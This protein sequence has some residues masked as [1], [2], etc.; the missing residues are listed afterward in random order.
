M[1][2]QMERRPLADTRDERENS[3]SWQTPDV[4]FG[5]RRRHWHTVSAF[6]WIAIL[7]VLTAIVMGASFGFAM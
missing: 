6:G 3:M 4:L 1:T 7:A 2:T 5:D